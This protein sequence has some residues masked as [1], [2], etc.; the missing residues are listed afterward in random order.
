ML[1]RSALVL[2][3]SGLVL[4]IACSNIANMLLARAAARRKE[5]G[6]RL[7]LGATRRRLV[8]Q[9][10]TESLLL[11]ALGGAAGVLLAWWSLDV[12][13]A[14]L[15]TRYGGGDPNHLALDLSP[16]IRVLAFALLLSLLS[17]LAFGLAPALRATRPD[18]IT[19][20]KDEGGSSGR[21][22]RSLLRSDTRTF[23]Y[24]K[25]ICD[26]QQILGFYQR[27]LLI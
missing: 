27:G 19:V 4:L 1:F 14:G 11:A 7:C 25:K 15:L 8:R 18:L 20:L 17:G 12:L 22:S 21:A 16:D 2:G 9:L 5:I 26:Q 10:L 24:T 6:L 23:G 3:A 13:L